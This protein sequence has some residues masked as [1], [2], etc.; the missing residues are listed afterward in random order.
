MNIHKNASMTPKG[1]AHLMREIDRI[2][3]RAAS[4]AAGLSVRG[5]RKWQRRHAVEGSAGL[6]DRSSRP[7]R[8]PGLG[9]P[10]KIERAVG[11]RRH[12]RLTYESIAE[13]VGLSRSAVAR[14]CKNDGLARLPAL[15]D[16]VHVRGY[17]HASPG[18]LLHLDT[19]KMGCVNQ[20][21]H[22]GTGQRRPNNPSDGWPARAMARP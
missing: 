1:R 9:D 2:G 5:A 11:L 4:A 18:E 12:Q 17:D 3:L 15:Q 6:L 22:R 20:P 19:K 21:G 10:A 16:A 14:A 13:R 7:H 8:C